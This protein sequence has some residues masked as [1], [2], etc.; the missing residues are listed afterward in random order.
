MT[1]LETY[2]LTEDE[3]DEIQNIYHQYN[4]ML[5]NSPKTYGAKEYNGDRPCLDPLAMAEL[6]LRLDGGTRTASKAPVLRALLRKLL[7]GAPSL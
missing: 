4:P 3:Y 6:R 5:L 7:R 1:Y 2:G